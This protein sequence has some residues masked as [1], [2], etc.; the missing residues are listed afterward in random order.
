[1]LGL[2]VQA[3]SLLYRDAR[4]RGWVEEVDGTYR[5]TVRGIEHL[6]RA[7]G[8][9]TMD[10]EARRRNLAIVRQCRAIAGEDLRAG[11]E[12]SLRMEDGLLVAVRGRRGP[13]RGR[14]LRSARRGALAEVG[15]LKGVVRL[16]PRPVAI[17]VLPDSWSPDDRV[18]APLLRA[19]R[20][21]RGL[22]VA[23]GLEAYHVVRSLVHAPVLRFGGAAAARE[24][25]QVGVPS[26]VVVTQERLPSLLRGLGEPPP[27][28]PI[29]V[30]TL[31][32][33]RGREPPGGP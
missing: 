12:V 4:A 33:S 10:L 3:V 29:R 18:P 8:G 30:S 11:E 22:L 25:S 21:H 31:S 27:G 28:P 24:A 26:L 16:E 15:E 2:S 14:V 23:E 7:F 6:H 17:Y 1:V 20:S 19:L 13:S 9:L 5:P 32:G